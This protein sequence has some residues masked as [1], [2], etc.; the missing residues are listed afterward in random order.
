MPKI[1]WNLDFDIHLTFGF[2]NLNFSLLRGMVSPI[3]I[4]IE[5]RVASV[6]TKM[7]GDKL[8]HF[9]LSRSSPAKIELFQTLLDPGVDRK[10]FEEI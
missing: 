10:G 2:L 3:M 7:V 1:F 9:L 6:G 5:L 8:F 4:K